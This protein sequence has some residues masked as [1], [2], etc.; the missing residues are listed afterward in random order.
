VARSGARLVG[1]TALSDRPYGRPLLRACGWQVLAGLLRRPWLVARLDWLRGTGAS[2]RSGAA[3]SRGHAAQ[4]AITCV[5][6]DARG[7]GIGRGLKQATIQACLDWG[8]ESI[9]AGVRRGDTWARALNEQAGF[10]EVPELSSE[11][12]VH[13]RLALDP[14]LHA[15]RGRT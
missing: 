2:P 12:L 7:G 5:A 3:R 15:G 14:G 13:L 9:I 10:V 6:A 4:I 8:V 1:L 11:R